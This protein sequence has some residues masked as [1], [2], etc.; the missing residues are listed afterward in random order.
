MRVK[1]REGDAEVRGSRAALELGWIEMVI[2]RSAAVCYEL[3][4]VL[5]IAVGRMMCPNATVTQNLR[6]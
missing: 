5:V 3:Y 2:L 1:D 6:M 4:R